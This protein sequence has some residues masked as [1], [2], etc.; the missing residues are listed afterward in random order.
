MISG[1][2]HHL[3][4]LEERC[5]NAESRTCF[6][7]KRE[8]V[9]DGRFGRPERSEW[10]LARPRSFALLRTAQKSAASTS[11]APAHSG[12]NDRGVAFEL[13]A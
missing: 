9:G 5:A 4:A 11:F 8:A 7:L 10:V 1:K 6:L 3:G 12:Q 13:F 2:Y